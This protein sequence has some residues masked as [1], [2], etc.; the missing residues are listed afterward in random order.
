MDKDAVEVEGG[1]LSKDLV[2]RYELKTQDDTLDQIIIYNYR[3][4]ER[5]RE[6]SS[7]IRWALSRMLEHVR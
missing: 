6:I 5:A 3:L 1:R 4:E 2:I 7:T